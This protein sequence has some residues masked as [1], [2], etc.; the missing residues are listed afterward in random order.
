VVVD[1]LPVPRWWQIPEPV[2]MTTQLL[3]HLPTHLSAREGWRHR[4]QTGDGLHLLWGCVLLHLAV[5]CCR[6]VKWLQTGEQ[7]RR[8]CTLRALLVWRPVT[9]TWLTS[10]FVAF[11]SPF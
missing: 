9:H 5:K 8:L 2:F 11:L 10:L 1:S 6:W 7:L 4:F 3:I